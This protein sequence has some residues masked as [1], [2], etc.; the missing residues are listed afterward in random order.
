MGFMA[1]ATPYLSAVALG[2]SAYQGIES[3]KGQ[4]KALRFQDESQK[5]AEAAAASERM[6]AQTDINKADRKKPDIA[7]M[8]AAARGGSGL[9]STMLTGGSFGR[10]GG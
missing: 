8:L 3:A 1:A 4:K 5:R 2:A 7:A 6:R 10:L 9:D